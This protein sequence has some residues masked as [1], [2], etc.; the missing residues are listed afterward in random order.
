MVL[1]STACSGK[2]KEDSNGVVQ[3]GG[4]NGGGTQKPNEGV[5]EVV[6][7]ADEC[8]E[9]IDN[10]IKS[11]YNLSS[12]EVLSVY[13]ERDSQGGLVVS[14]HEGYRNKDKFEG[15]EF[16]FRIKVD[17][18]IHEAKV[19]IPTKIYNDNVFDNLKNSNTYN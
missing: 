14:M 3:G 7:T 1:T 16:V 4:S 18:S 8:L 10:F 2:N 15:V 17:E 19:P 5:V 6:V 9:T 12:C 13:T 11:H